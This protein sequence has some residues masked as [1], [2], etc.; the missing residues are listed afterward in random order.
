MYTQTNANKI[1]AATAPRIQ[2]ALASGCCGANGLFHPGGGVCLR[3]FG[4]A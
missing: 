2:R 4:I 3:S 1:V